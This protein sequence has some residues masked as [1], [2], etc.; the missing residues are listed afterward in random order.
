LA[1][2]ARRANDWPR[3]RVGLTIGLEIGLDLIDIRERDQP[4]ALSAL[5]PRPLAV[6][7]SR[8]RLV[9]ASG[10]FEFGIDLEFVVDLLPKLHEILLG[11]WLGVP[12]AESVCK[13]VKCQPNDCQDDDDFNDSGSFGLVAVLLF[14]ALAT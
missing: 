13:F 2:L 5:S 4:P 12:E 3:W 9:Q 6:F 11:V 7:E 8:I 10:P 14:F 1:S